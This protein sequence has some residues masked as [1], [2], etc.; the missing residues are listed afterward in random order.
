[1]RRAGRRFR[2]RGASVTLGVELPP[3]VTLRRSRHPGSI[4]DLRSATW[5]AMRT[6]KPL[7]FFYYDENRTVAWQQTSEEGRNPPHRR[8]ISP[9]CLHGIGLC[10]MP[11]NEQTGFSSDASSG[12]EQP[13]SYA[14]HSELLAYLHPL[15]IYLKFSQWHCCSMRQLLPF[16]P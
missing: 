7:G 5:S 16:A 4:E 6:A 9:S 14:K 8:S 10:S 2:K 13:A 3:T 1:M 11:T 15:H 12:C